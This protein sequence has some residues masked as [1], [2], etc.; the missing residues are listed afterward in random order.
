M[1]DP[2]LLV[3]MAITA[4][5]MLTMNPVKASSAVD[6]QGLSEQDQLSPETYMSSDGTVYVLHI[7]MWIAER[8]TKF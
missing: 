5:I 6:A 1:F 4:F 8:L 7:G 2:V 3:Q